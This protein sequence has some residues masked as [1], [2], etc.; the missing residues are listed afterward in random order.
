MGNFLV[1]LSSESGGNVI[2]TY[3]NSRLTGVK[4]KYVNH[5]NENA[6]FF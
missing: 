1:N 5:R 6:E 2:K 3:I 4:I